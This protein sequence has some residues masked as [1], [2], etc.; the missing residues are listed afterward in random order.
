[1]SFVK[2][3][4]AQVDLK[5]PGTFDLGEVHGNFQANAQYYIADSTIGAA[6]APEKM[7][8]NG[9]ANILYTKGKFTAGIRYE[10]YLNVLQGYPT[11]YKGTGIPYRFITYKSDFLEITAGS[12]YE[13][14]GNGLILRTYEERNLGLDNAL[15]GVRIKAE[16]VKGI[17]MKGLIGKQRSFFSQGPGIVRGI[18]GEI[19]I[20]ELFSKLANKKLIVGIGGGFVSKFQEDQDP[21]LVLPQNVGSQAIRFNLSRNNFSMNGEYAYKINDPSLDN[22]FIYK[23][24]N[25]TLLQASYAAKGFALTVAGS[26]IENM[27]FRSDRNAQLTNLL[28]N[29]IPALN[30]QHTY[31]L[32]TFYPYA[33]QAKGEME[34]STELKYKFKKG[35]ALGGKYGTEI[36][37]NYSGSN[38]LDTTNLKPDEDWRKMG[39][40]SRYFIIGNQIYF[41]DLY[42]EIN[43]KFS[44]KWKASFIYSYQVYNKD[45]IQKP[46]GGMIYS[47]IGVVDLTYKLK[48]GALRLELQNMSTKQDQQDWAY[49]LLEY[50]VNTNWYIAVGDQYNYGNVIEEARYHYYNISTGYI[51]NANRIELSYGKQR[52]GIFCVGGVCR[53]VPAMNGVTLT[54]TSSF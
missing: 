7:L 35:S 21:L 11:G 29:Y 6:A 20:N 44:S 31:S 15:D 54:I 14:F 2:L 34:F 32:L 5:K 12:F 38:S 40:K 8:F 28:L 48:K 26:R 1:M 52:Q 25:A 37:I 41:R 42:V 49:A 13:Q 9:F 22:N 27:S 23:P 16:P 45:V 53:N 36:L 50:T 10:N 17:Y 51:K 46:G 24:G 39:Y 18:D 19:Q 3:S 4:S 33:S 30:K 43:K 47:N